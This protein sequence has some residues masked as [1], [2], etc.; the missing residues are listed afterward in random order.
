VYQQIGL[1]LSILALVLSLTAAAAESTYYDPTG[2]GN[3][4]RDADPEVHPIK[5]ANSRF[6][7]PWDGSF[8]EDYYDFLVAEDRFMTDEELEGYILKSYFKDGK[9]SLEGYREAYDLFRASLE[10]TRRNEDSAEDRRRWFEAALRAAAIYLDA[11]SVNSNL[12][13]QVWFLFD[14]KDSFRETDAWFCDELM[15]I[16]G[17]QVEG[18]PAE[19]AGALCNM[20][21]LQL[22]KGNDMLAKESRWIMATIAER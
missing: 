15:G 6:K 8:L 13:L 14:E 2:H 9:I 20:G 1:L 12:S 17:A 5:S 4:Y 10:M 22:A 21:Y 11:N 18:S 3:V 19:R 16:F 7:P